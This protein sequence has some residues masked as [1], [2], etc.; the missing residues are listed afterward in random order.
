LPG[1]GSDSRHAASAVAVAAS[2]VVLALGACGEDSD[3]EE[4]V[5]VGEVRIGSVAALAEC[6]DWNAGNEEQQLATIDDIR[7]QIN[8]QDAPVEVPELS[9]ERA[10]ELFENACEPPYA[11]SFR[12]HKLYSRATG[13]SSLLEPSLA[14]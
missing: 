9:D 1:T 2:V 12:L 13:F 7:E 4:P 5:G 6:R 10:Y 3:S 14:P 8:L 11:K